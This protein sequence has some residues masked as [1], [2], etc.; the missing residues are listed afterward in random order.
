MKKYDVSVIVPVFNL[1]LYI[2][3]CVDSIINQ[4]IFDKIELILINDGS[5]DNSLKIMEEYEEKYEN[6]IIISQINSGV[7]A[8][9]NVG[10]KN[11][12][13]KY[14]LFVDGDDFI[15][16]DYIENLFIATDKEEYDMVIADYWLYYSENNLKRYRNINKQKE[17]NS[18]EAIKELLSG[19]LVGNNLFDK[20]FKR[21]LLNGVEFNS[22]IKIG[23]DLLFIYNYLK[24]A[25]RI[26][27]TFL[28]GYYYVQREGS[29]MNS[30]FSEKQFDILKV[31]NKIQNDICTED[32]ELINIYQAFDIYC[33]Y[34]IVER[35]LKNKNYNMYK[36]RI[37]DLKIEIR[38]YSII[39]GFK[40][41]SK[42]RFLG[43]ILIKYFPH[44][45]LWV[46]KIKKI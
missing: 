29:A 37:E 2:S 25:K 32:N 4:T 44:T 41:L 5:K 28:P 6:I 31:S 38:K 42:N 10:I 19:G 43:L 34:K 46:C 17:W 40:Y 36:D 39:K 12:H 21:T 23:E 16:T 1:E 24:N 18:Q 14:V 9:R 22:D 20:I 45:Y 33:K 15:N 30:S 11:A 26:L 8:A 13:G 7:S 35:A 27:G 3:R